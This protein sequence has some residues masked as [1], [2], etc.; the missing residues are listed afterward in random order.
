MRGR[1]KDIVKARRHNMF[2]TPLACSICVFIDDRPIENAYTVLNGQAVC[3]DH[4]YIVQTNAFIS[5]V[6][7]AKDNDE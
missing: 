7:F 2:A 4:M 6:R 1:L 5:L 3:E